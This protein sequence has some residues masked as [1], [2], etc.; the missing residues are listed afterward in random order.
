MYIKSGANGKIPEGDDV[1]IGKN[2][3]FIHFTSNEM[4]PFNLN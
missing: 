3:H 1:V 2:M 4:K